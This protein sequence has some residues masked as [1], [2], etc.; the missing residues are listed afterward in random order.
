VLGRCMTGPFRQFK[1][2]SWSPYSR[3]FRQHRQGDLGESRTTQAIAT[4]NTHRCDNSRGVVTHPG[5]RVGLRRCQEADAGSVDAVGAA[6]VAGMFFVQ[7]GDYRLALVLFVISLIGATASTVFY[8]AFAATY[9][10]RRRDRPCFERGV[11][12]RVYRRRF[13]AGVESCVDSQ[14]R[15]VR[16]PHRRGTIE[17]A[18]NAADRLALLSVAVWWLVFSIPLFR[19]FR[20]RREP[21]NRTSSRQG[22][23]SS[24]R[25]SG[26]GDV[27]ARYEATSRRFSC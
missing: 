23:Y 11:R 5:S 8:D 6:A 25:L 20:N 3:V 24:L 22:V 12:R 1:P 27:S 4:A 10:G 14:A 9:R 15:M 18:E 17:C 19:G 7:Q 21:A 13:A 2:R 16:P 26:W